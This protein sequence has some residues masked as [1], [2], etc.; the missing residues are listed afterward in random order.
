MKVKGTLLTSAL[1]CL[2]WSHQ[3]FSPNYV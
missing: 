3:N 2:D 1:R